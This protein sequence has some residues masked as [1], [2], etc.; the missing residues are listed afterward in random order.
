[1]GRWARGGFARK[2]PSKA[3][4]RR[5]PETKPSDDTRR[6]FR[7][8]PGHARDAGGCVWV[9][10]LG[11][12]GEGGEGGGVGRPLHERG[13][14]DP[15]VF[16]GADLVRL[17]RIRP[18]AGISAR[19]GIGT[20][21]ARSVLLPPPASDGVL[22]VGLARRSGEANVRPEEAVWPGESHDAGG[23]PGVRGASS[24]AIYSQLYRVVLYCKLPWSRVRLSAH[25]RMPYTKTKIDC[26]HIDGAPPPALV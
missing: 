20:L 4:Q 9:H 25:E 22:L 23:W 1:M 3:K 18:R 5:T 2:E 16:V 26:T 11:R 14:A 21:A 13:H 6:V 7:R 10:R 15:A 12:A 24:T 19:A 8:A 17:S